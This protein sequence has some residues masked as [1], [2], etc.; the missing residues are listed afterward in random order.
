MSRQVRRVPLDFDWPMNKVWEGYLLPERLHSD[1]CPDCSG[2][3]TAAGE[4][5]FKL[6]TR[7]DML[8]EDI[9][10]QR[11]GRPMH[12]YLA[13]DQDPATTRFVFGPGG[14]TEYPKLL[15]PSQ[16]IL[17]LVA[18]LSGET[19]EHLTSP[20]RGMST[21]TF[22]TV[23]KAAGLDPTVWAICPTCDGHSGVER[24]P[25]QRAEAEAWEPTGPPTGEGWQLWE[26]T[27][28]GSP[29]SPVF[30]T[31][32]GLTTWMSH[33]D[34]GDDWVH[35]HVAANF[36]KVGWAPSGASGP[37]IHG[38]ISGVELIGTT[39]EQEGPTE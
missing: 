22:K 19:P 15:R 39:F 10:A 13:Q 34:R 11:R 12:P 21:G 6:C 32:D 38:V 2:G 30:P 37:G 5:L 8:A 23:I 20:M 28:D 24:F 7:I 16:D 3:M 14:A 31:A 17:E 35:P 25:G 4:W 29:I 33:P 26:T 36:I 9:G 1:R 27:S 18:G